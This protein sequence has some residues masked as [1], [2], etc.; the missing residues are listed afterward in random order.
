MSAFPPKPDIRDEPV[1]CPVLTTHRRQSS[2]INP[3]AS[4]PLDDYSPSSS[5]K[6]SFRSFTKPSQR[7]RTSRTGRRPGP[8]RAHSHTTRIRQPLSCSAPRAARSRR[9]LPV[10]FSCQ[11]SALVAGHL[12]IGQSCPC[13]KHPCTWITALYLGNTRSGFPGRSFRCNRKR[14]PRAWRPCRRISSGLVSRPRMRLIFRRRCSGVRTSTI[15][16]LS[17]I[18]GICGLNDRRHFLHAQDG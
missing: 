5:A 11:N 4:P 15:V 3:F 13:Q 12:N 14:K 10:I 6:A 7:L 16:P 8:R 17:S 9:R 2:R 1:E 18:A